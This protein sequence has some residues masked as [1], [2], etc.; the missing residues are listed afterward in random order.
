MSGQQMIGEEEEHGGRRPEIGIDPPAKVREIVEIVGRLA[1]RG[2]LRRI[3][4]IGQPGE[5]GRHVASQV[6]MALQES[7]DH[8]VV[9]GFAR[10]IVAEDGGP[11]PGAPGIDGQRHRAGECDQQRTGRKRGARGG[12]GDRGLSGRM[13]RATSFGRRG[14]REKNWRREGDSNPRKDCSFT[15]LAN[16]RFR[17]LSHLSGQSEEGKPRPAE[18]QGQR[19]PYSSPGRSSSSRHSLMTRSQISRRS[20]RRGR[21]SSR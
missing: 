13:A 20:N 10:I 11:E 7:V 15:G 5:G 17:P 21:A 16:L 8:P 1:K 2:V 19:Q 3:V 6:E 12:D 18:G 14:G 9:G 4:R